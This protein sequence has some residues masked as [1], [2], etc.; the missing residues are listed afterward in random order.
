[1]IT[2]NDLTQAHFLEH[3]FARY[4]DTRFFYPNLTGQRQALEA[5]HQFILN[6]KDPAK[7]LGVVSGGSGSGKSM[8]AMK[9]AE[10]R[11]ASDGRSNVFGLYMNTNTVTG[12][13]HFLMAVIE[14]LGLPSSRSNANRV[15]SI[16]E[17]LSATDDQLLLVL[18]GPPVD[19][20]YLTQLLEWSV[21]NQRKIK[22][23]VFLQDLNNVTSNIGSLNR[24]LGQYLTFPAPSAPEIA[25]L[26]F[27]RCL[28]AGHPAPFS[29]LP[30]EVFL[31][32]AQE[33]HGSLSEA[34]R[35]ASS[36]L[37]ADLEAQKAQQ[38]LT[39]FRKWK[40]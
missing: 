40:I 19:Q 13:R 23:V 1:M 17:R 38:I 9:L 28:A 35:L 39:N 22:A 11:F 18:D 32:I 14:T 21:E 7:N 6:Q 8:L 5:T 3:P 10:T 2:P 25:N 37:E 20:E 31:E 27:W 34:L 30:E 16:F 4:A 15:E 24:F 12:P 29:L 26:L 33:A 36:R